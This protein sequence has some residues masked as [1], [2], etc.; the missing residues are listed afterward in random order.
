MNGRIYLFPAYCVCIRVCARV[1]VYFSGCMFLDE[2]ELKRA[3]IS[4]RICGMELTLINARH[5]PKMDIVVRKVAP[6]CS[7]EMRAILPE[8]SRF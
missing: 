1:L 5:L 2:L 7:Q 3:G 4:K 8:Y 6:A